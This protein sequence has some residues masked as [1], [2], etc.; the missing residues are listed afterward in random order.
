MPRIFKGSESTLRLLCH[1]CN[2]EGKISD[3]K[4]ALYTNDPSMAVEFTGGY[5]IEGNIVS[6]TVPNYAFG[7]MEDGVINYVAQGMIDDNTFLTERQSNY[8]LKTPANYTPTL[9]QYNT[10]ADI[11]GSSPESTVSFKGFVALSFK[12]ANG[13]YILF[14]DHT[15]SILLRNNQD[16]FNV[17]DECVVT[18]RLRRND[19]TNISFLLE[20]SV[21]VLSSNNYVV[22]PAEAVELTN[23]DDLYKPNEN[24]YAEMKYLF[25]D[26]KVGDRLTEDFMRLETDASS[27]GYI[28]LRGNFKDWVE[29]LKEGDNI[30]VYMFTDISAN[31]SFVVTDIIQLGTEGGSC[32]LEDKGV[33]PSMADRD[34]NGVIVI[35]ESEGFDGLDR[36]V[37]DPSTIYNE[38]YNKALENVD[39]P[40]VELYATENGEYLPQRTITEVIPY[41]DMDGDDVFSLN[42]GCGLIEE[43]IEFTLRFR[44]KSFI[45]DDTISNIFGLEQADWDDSTFAIREYGGNF[46]VK[47]GSFHQM[48]RS[49]NEW[50]TLKMG[51]TVNNETI[52]IEF[53]GERYETTGADSTFVRWAEPVYIGATN[54]GGEYFRNCKID[55]EWIEYIGSNGKGRWTP[56]DGGFAVEFNGGISENTDNLAGGYAMTRNEEVVTTEDVL[57]FSKVVVDVPQNGGGDCNIQEYK[58]VR[59]SMADRKENGD[60]YIYPDEGFDAVGYIDFDPS[61]IYNEGVEEGRNQGGGSGDCNIQGNKTVELD[62]DRMGIYPDEG[63]NGIFEVIV[64]A[65]NKAED[66]REEGRYGVREKLQTIEITENGR[67]ST[68]DEIYVDSLRYNGGYHTDTISTYDINRIEVTFKADTSES[69]NGQGRPFIFGG[70]LFGVEDVYGTNNA[71]ARALQYSYGR[72]VGYWEGKWTDATPTSD[73][74]WLTIT[75]DENGMTVKYPTGEAYMEYTHDNGNTNNGADIFPF[76]IGGLGGRA[77]DESGNYTA[78]LIED[79]Q[80]RGLIKEVKINTNSM[81]EITYIPKNW[82][83][84]VWD[85]IVENTGEHLSALEPT[86][87][88]VTMNGEWERK[89]G[90]GWKEIN[91]NI[92]PAK[93]IYKETTYAWLMYNGQD[94]SDVLSSNFEIKLRDNT[95]I[96]DVAPGYPGSSY[97]K[98]GPLLI[99]GS[100]DENQITEINNLV[101]NAASNQYEVSYCPVIYF[102]EMYCGNVQKISNDAFKYMDELLVVGPMTN[103]GESFK[104]EI[105]LNFENCEHLFKYGVAYAAEDF[106]KSLYDFS[107]GPN[108]NG[109]TTSYIKLYGKF[110]RHDNFKNWVAERGWTLIESE[111]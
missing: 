33:S 28:N 24:G 93:N 22:M 100:L 63:Y 16:F 43:F 82:G 103:L 21:E 81:G 104:G 102:G 17:G 86:E 6:L 1:T 89:Y 53:D 73:G 78:N 4:I 26:G 106:I 35:E 83:Y 60:I 13:N 50:H 58:W 11:Y 41:L 69:I 108:K 34:G 91:V 71:C 68:E 32:N 76:I 107:K 109:V 84:G 7:T 94:T 37:I 40:L 39:K 47:I 8:F 72:I 10:I 54:T 49:D 42:V 36:V 110:G 38:G 5:T 23:V 51:A 55:V 99:C 30:R 95:T 3:L 62:G 48:F 74:E 85:R 18:A 64:D 57:G 88:E 56:I 14:T 20:A 2:Q 12:Y 70:S 77:V 75:L 29:K 65:R 15:G 80:F 87:G 44:W 19:D 61:D 52:Y 45:T 59:P 67:Y 97:H 79:T 98:E 105:I 46:D 101:Y 27:K 66:W 9:K 31:P 92:V 96:S 25:V 90:E 111:E